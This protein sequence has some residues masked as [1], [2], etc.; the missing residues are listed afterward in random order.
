MLDTTMVGLCCV[1]LVYAAAHDIAARTIPNAVSVMIGAAGAIHAACRN[2]IWACFAVAIVVFLVGA[3]GWRARLLGGGDVKL[4]A[5]LSLWIGPAGTAPWLLAVSIAGG[6]LACL[7][8][9][10]RLVLPARH[11]PKPKGFLARVWRAEWRRIR[12][13]HSLPY[14]VAIAAASIDFMVV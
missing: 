4:L 5:A 8:L 14:A 1:G 7:Y 6:I 10:L 2:E 13:R 9:V 11:G 3:A 12:M